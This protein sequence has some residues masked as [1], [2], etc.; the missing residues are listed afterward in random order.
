MIILHHLESSQ[1]FRIVWLL[2][3]LGYKYDLKLYKRQDDK[4]APP[5]YKELSPLGTSPTIEDG[6]VVLC[7]SNA[8][9]DY[10]LDQ[11]PPSS[12]L[13][14]SP[15]SPT[16]ADYLFWFHAAQGTFQ[17]NL[18]IDSLMRITPTRAPWPISI[19]ARMISKKT[20]ARF[21]QPRLKRYLSLAD[22]QLSKHNYFAG[23]SEL[24]AADI[25]SIYPMDAAFNR[26]PHFR[27]KF[28]HCQ[29]WLERVSERPAFQKA[30]EKVGEDHVS[31]HI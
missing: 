16:R 22:T 3:E 21:V 7:E 12:T 31:L 4:T 5:E 1:S 27:E 20:Q 10:L 11:A 26:Y 14:P 24:T 19:I 13:R 6:D 2:E 28:P 15:Q 25:T 8:I 30:L 23:S 29:A 18:A 9:I 17:L